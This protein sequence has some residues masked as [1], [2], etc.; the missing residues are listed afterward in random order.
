MSSSEVVE[1]ALL[2]A[3]LASRNAMAFALAFFALTSVL[4]VSS[5][6]KTSTFRSY[7]GQGILALAHF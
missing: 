2:F 6:K 1:E 4:A 3:Y 5:W 7:P